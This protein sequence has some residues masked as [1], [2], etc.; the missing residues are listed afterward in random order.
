[1]PRDSVRQSANLLAV[2][3]ALAVNVLAVTLPLNG[4]DTA[5]IS[6][7]FP[8]YFVPAGYVFSIWG[9]I[10][11]GWIAFVIYQF[12]PQHKENPR[13]RKLGYL[14]ALSCVFNAG[15]LF[16]WHYLLHGARLLFLDDG[17]GGEKQR[18]QHDQK[19]NDA[20]DE[21]MLT[22]QVGIVPGPDTCHRFLP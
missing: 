21:E 6:D 18:E 1:M 16:C 9:L 15:W 8:I 11:I 14:F 17:H 20:G 12:L 10:Y 22:V 19:G 3:A 5:A 13:L 4:Q 2:V 7:R